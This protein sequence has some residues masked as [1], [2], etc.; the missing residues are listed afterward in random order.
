MYW[1]IVG[2]I[3]IYFSVCGDGNIEA[4]A[5]VPA[6]GLRESSVE[7]EQAPAVAPT[8]DQTTVPAQD[9]HLAEGELLIHSFISL[10]CH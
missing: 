10:F 8:E 2:H 9:A 6:D 5:E 1:L 7:P 4:P 3:T